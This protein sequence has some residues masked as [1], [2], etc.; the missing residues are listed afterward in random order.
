MSHPDEEI[1][2]QYREQMTKLAHLID[3][4]FNGPPGPGKVKNTG[5]FLCVFPFD[6]FDGRSNYISN[7]DRKEIIVLL[8][9]MA[10]RFQGQ[11]ELQ[12]RA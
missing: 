11:P 8:K 4:F 7:A 2:L 1:E 6:G 5:F 9:E 3:E 10:A 12:G